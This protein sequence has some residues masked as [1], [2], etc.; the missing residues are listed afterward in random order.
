[1]RNKGVREGLRKRI[2][3]YEGN[4]KKDESGEEIGKKFWMAKEYSL[5]SLL[6][7]LLIADLEEE[8]GKVR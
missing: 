5:S 2:G 7:N 3:D 1:M 6:F 4:E 8:I